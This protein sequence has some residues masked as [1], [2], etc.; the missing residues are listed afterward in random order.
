MVTFDKFKCW[1]VVDGEPLKEH[2][3]TDINKE[4]ELA[5]KTMTRFVEAQPGEKFGIKVR[6]GSKFTYKNADD[7]CWALYTD[8]IYR[9]SI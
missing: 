9:T 3:D 7:V 4:T 2:V 5:T 8:G 1:V 6:I